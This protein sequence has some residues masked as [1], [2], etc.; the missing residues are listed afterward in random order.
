MKKI[1]TS[2]LLVMVII[3]TMTAC[4]NLGTQTV[5]SAEENTI[6]E[7]RPER[8]VE[9]FQHDEETGMLVDPPED[10][11]AYL[12][13]IV[14]I[15]ATEDLDWPD[16]RAIGRNF[17]DIWEIYNS[18]CD[19]TE[20]EAQAIAAFDN[21]LEQAHQKNIPM[22]QIDSWTD[23]PV[24]EVLCKFYS[25][26]NVSHPGSPY[27]FIP[28]WYLTEDEVIS[29]AEVYFSNPVFA[30]NTVMATALLTYYPD[31]TAADMAWEHIV[32]ASKSTDSTLSE[33]TTTYFTCLDIF[34][35]HPEL[36]NNTE[37][38]TEI[39]NNILQNDNFNFEQ[40][41]VYL[42]SDFTSEAGIEDDLDK[43][44]NDIAFESLLELAQNATKENYESIAKVV[45]K[46]YD[47]YGIES[48]L[49][50]SLQDNY[51]VELLTGCLVEW[52][53]IANTKLPSYY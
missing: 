15:S 40:K 18:S 41:Y 53:K 17:S 25:N 12:A 46:L 47:K 36:L 48:T 22:D 43:E 49:V 5:A 14:H 7:T 21:V 51:N 30:T 32:S 39:A 23:V 52:K 29:V 13:E 9:Y 28:F 19:K 16:M 34:R 35:R 37:K 26:Q 45:I 50:E 10:I 44:I 31:G 20:F 11:S 6:T 38:I 2:I 24:V 3:L 33:S 8:K 27:W 4:V 42:C 1:I